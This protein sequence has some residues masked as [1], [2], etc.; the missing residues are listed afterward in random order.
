[1]TITYGQPDFL[2]VGCFGW[3]RAKTAREAYRAARANSSPS[4]LKPAGRIFRVWRIADQIDQ[5]VV[6]EIDGSW[7]GKPKEGLTIPKGVNACKLVWQGNDKVKLTD[8]P[9]LP[10]KAITA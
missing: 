5:I 2:C 1:M 8:V 9:E 3:A 7:Y 6:S 4:M 10:T